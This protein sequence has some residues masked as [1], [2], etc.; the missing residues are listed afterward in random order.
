MPHPSAFS[1]ILVADVGPSLH[2][3]T[4]LRPVTDG[5]DDVEQQSAI[6][7]SASVPCPKCCKSG[8]MA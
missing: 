7:E 4:Y 6:M 2:D 3:N 8:V 1:A 5:T